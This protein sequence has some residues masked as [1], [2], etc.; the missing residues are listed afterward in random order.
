M[1][2]A[3]E[4]QHKV[5]TVYAAGI[6]VGGKLGMLA[7]QRMPYI[8]KAAAI[9]SPCFHYDGWNV[10]FYYPILSRNIVWLSRIPF[11]HRLSFQETSSIGIKDAR[12]RRMME[13][14]SAEGV[15][16]N[17]PGK[18]LVEMHRLGK[19]LKNELPRMTT[20]ILILHAEEDDL[21]D[22]RNARLIAN[23]ISS[24][25]KLA[26]IKDSYHMIHVDAQHKQVA[27]LTANFF[28]EAYYA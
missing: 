26:W 5:E 9:Y 25:H 3:Q 22:P 20:P 10:P 21:S 11:L 18:A 14:M 7:A 2:A 4:L 27:Q 8:I 6:C 12:L 28:N 13:G 1:Q 16:E 17:F 23:H 24:P 19:A 15:I